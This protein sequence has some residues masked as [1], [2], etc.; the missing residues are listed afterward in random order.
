[1]NQ[2]ETGIFQLHF[3]LFKYFKI[4]KVL[5]YVNTEPNVDIV[6]IERQAEK[7]FIT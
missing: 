1:M 7:Y 2:E 3:V 5:K 6:F 4:V